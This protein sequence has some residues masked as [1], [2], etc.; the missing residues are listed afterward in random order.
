MEWVFLTRRDATEWAEVP[1]HQIGPTMRR[2]SL[3]ALAA[4]VAAGGCSGDA[5]SPGPTGTT[6]EVT[7]APP[8]SVG[9][10]GNVPDAC[11]L[12]TP[13]ELSQFL[14][15][16]VSD[17]GTPQSVSPDRSICIYEGGVITAVEIA[18]N[19][20]GTRERI[21]AEGRTTTDV[22]GVGERA[23][24]DDAGQIVASGETVF[25]AITAS[26]VPPEQLA[27]AARIML[28]NAGET[29]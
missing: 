3:L 13:A 4:L 17:E 24:Y 5:P 18:A 23:F 10:T 27:G 16:T 6:S 21:E 11:T 15:T 26:G 9:E 19:Y 20:D 14:G 7:T 1:A 22:A 28:T 8:T 12:I 29:P 25:V 2:L